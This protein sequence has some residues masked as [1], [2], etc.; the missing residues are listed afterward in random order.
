[1]SSDDYDRYHVLDYVLPALVT[2]MDQGAGLTP[3]EVILDAIADVNRTDAEALGVPL[4]A[5]DYGYV[6]QTLREFFTSE[7]RGF[8]QLYYI[9]Q[10]RPRE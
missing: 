5:R 7:T 4:D 6:M 9:V 1:M 8:E 10:N 3:L 2:P